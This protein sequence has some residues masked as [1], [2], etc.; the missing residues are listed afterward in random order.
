MSVPPHNQQD[1]PMPGQESNEGSAG[2]PIDAIVLEALKLPADD[3][4]AFLRSKCTGDNLFLAQALDKLKSSSPQ[5]WDMSIESRAFDRADAAHE[6]T[7]EMIGPYR[8]IRN[9]APAAWARSYWPSATTGNF[10]NKCDKA[11]EA[12]HAIANRSSAVE[13]GTAD[14]RY[15]S[16]S[17]HRSVIGWWNR[18]GRHALYRNGNTLKASR[19]TPTATAI[20]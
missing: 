5:W 18:R 15:G 13:N 6:R 9:L 17:Q 7:G 14:T 8:V 12:R 11:S 3:R 4:M 19:W 16:T 10:A 2:D 1:P 20:S